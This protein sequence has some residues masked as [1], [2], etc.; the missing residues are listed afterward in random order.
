MIKCH[1]CLA[2]CEDTQELCPVCGAELKAETEQETVQEDDIIVNPTLLT[3][4]EDLISAEIFMDI[5]R[6]NEI[7]FSSS[8]QMGEATLQVTFGGCLASEDIYVGENDFERAS[9]ILED[10]LSS[11]I[12][13]DGDLEFDQDEEL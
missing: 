6:E 13:F 3:T 11:E 5:L 7:P 10:F 8:S 1:V 9:E 12:S 2:E 4:F